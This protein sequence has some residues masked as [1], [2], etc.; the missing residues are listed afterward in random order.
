MTAEQLIP[1]GTTPF[2][3]DPYIGRLLKPGQDF[4]GADGFVSLQ[5][6][7]DEI[8]SS[9]KRVIL[10]VGDSSTSG[11]DTRVTVENQERRK[12]EQP[13]LS[14]FFRYANYSDMLRDRVGG[15]FI[16]LNAGIPGHTS[17][18]TERRLRGLLDT[19]GKQAIQVDYVS[20]YAGNNDC[21]WEGN[22]EDKTRLRTSPLIP[23]FIDRLRLKFFKPDTKHI[24]LRTNQ[25]DFSRNLKRMLEACRRHSVAPVVILPETPLYWEPG[26]RFVADLFPVDEKIP[27]GAMVIAAL[28]RATE[29]WAAVLDQPWSED[30]HKALESA[31]ELDF[32]IPRIKKQY[33]QLVENIARSLEVPLV[34]TCIPREQDDGAYFV[35]YCHPIG[36]ANEAI[37][38]KLVEAIEDYE[39]GRV[40][41]VVA[42]TPL[43][44]RLLD[45]RFVDVVSGWFSGSRGRTA[46]SDP[47][48]QDIYTLY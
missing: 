10:N 15:D 48:N 23:I 8:R 32:V 26:K 45:S 14:A 22:R 27:G 40:S 43:L 46:E 39:S 3:D 25:R 2:S 44:Y 6:A 12:N 5:E 38:G 21:Q 37:A 36:R 7:V 28:K 11:W 34:R 29:R 17:V 20:I 4:I 41:K 1:H 33:R 19:L 35:D 13:L 16:V 24:R 30:K 18:N 9:S 31:R 42:R 47:E